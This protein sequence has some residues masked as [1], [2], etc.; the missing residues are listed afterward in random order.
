M[1]QGS[2]AEGPLQNHG[3]LTESYDG[4]HSCVLQVPPVTAAAAT[5]APPFSTPRVA[6]TCGD[7]ADFEEI[8]TF[9][10]GGYIH[11]VAGG[12][13]AEEGHSGALRP[14]F[15]LVGGHLGWPHAPR[16]L[17]AGL[18]RFR[19]RPPVRS[20]PNDR[21]EPPVRRSFRFACFFFFCYV[22]LYFSTV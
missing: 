22:F 1:N 5:P 8:R 10:G 11:D 4:S 21:R 7:C 13:V 3:F 18:R 16:L 9:D 19:C 12:R 6:S 2:E 15:R 17:R 20:D 14:V